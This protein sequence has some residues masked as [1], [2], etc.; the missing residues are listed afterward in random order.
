M[1]PTSVVHVIDDDEAVRDSL[2]FLLNT[3]RLAVR[4][5][6]SATTFLSALPNAEPGC[7]ITD[8]RMPEMSGV[9]L[10]RRLKEL[11]VPM[12]VIVLP[13]QG[14]FRLAVEAIKRGAI[15]C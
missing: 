15:P 13:A 10:L 2:T 4:A 14:E 8:V 3:A 5:Y 11:N 1:Q 9:D 6:D 12:P 7:I